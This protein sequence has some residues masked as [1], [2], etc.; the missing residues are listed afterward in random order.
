MHPLEIHLESVQETDDPEA[1]MILLT[2]QRIKFLCVCTYSFL[3]VSPVSGE[4]RDFEDAVDRVRAVD[5]PRDRQGEPLGPL[6][7]ASATGPPGG[8]RGR[9]P[10]EGAEE[11]DG[12]NQAQELHFEGHFCFEQSL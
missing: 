10:E 9:G 7:V 11:E 2:K 4:F 8:R 5:E 1:P 12:A 3:S 6:A